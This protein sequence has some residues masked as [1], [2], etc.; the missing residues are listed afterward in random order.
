M[1]GHLG[2]ITFTGKSGQKYYFHAWPLQ[3][4]F[5]SGGAVFLITKRVVNH[6]GRPSHEMMCIGQTGDF[7]ASPS[8]PG[9]LQ[10]LS[11][12]G[13]NCICV[14]AVVDDNRRM[15]AVRDLQNGLDLA[16]VQLDA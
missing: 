3:T 15:E 4:R 13:A 8:I 14:H 12:K 1:S 10:E 2:N 7:G 9:L 11:T 16:R 6:R 5:K